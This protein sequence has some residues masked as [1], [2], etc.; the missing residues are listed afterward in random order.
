MNRILMRLTAATA[1]VAGALVL[2]GAAHADVI[3]GDV[4]VNAPI[5]VVVENVLNNLTALLHIL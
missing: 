3:D 1:T 4:I 2:P 5:N